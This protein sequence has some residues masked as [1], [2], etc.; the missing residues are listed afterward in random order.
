M[1]AGNTFTS[2]YNVSQYTA[3]SSVTIA[4]IPNTY[5]DLF[6]TMTYGGPRDQD[7]HVRFNSDTSSNYGYSYI[8]ANNS[9]TISA[10]GA[11]SVN[12]GIV[13]LNGGYRGSITN[14][15]IPNYKNT[16]KYKNW[17]AQ[18]MG[19]ED[20]STY[21]YANIHGGCYRSTSA[22]SSIT[23]YWSNASQFQDSTAYG[24][25]INIYGITEA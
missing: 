24:L 16:N 23:F 25:K 9:S 19:W 6:L 3:V 21:N 17:F 8:R 12:Q 15:W 18:S 11:S 7:V 13:N 2:I 22:I 4:N 10:G 5:T 14:L 20:S 1:P